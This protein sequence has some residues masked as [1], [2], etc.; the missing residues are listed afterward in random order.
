MSPHPSIEGRGSQPG[1]GVWLRANGGGSGGGS[2]GG[3]R[4]ERTN[5]NHDVVDVC[6]KLRSP[7]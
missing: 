2:G 4:G 1:D 7:T 6:L 5:I 3:G